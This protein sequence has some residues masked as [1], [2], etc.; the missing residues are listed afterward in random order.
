MVVL[1]VEDDDDIRNEIYKLMSHFFFK[2][3]VARNGEEGL[4]LFL[5]NQDEINLILSD[6]NMPEMNGIE[7]VKKIREFDK[8]INIFFITA[9]SD[10]E[11]LIEAINLRIQE[12]IVK[13]V[14]VRKLL[15]SINELALIIYQDE[16]L[17]NQKKELEK[18]KEIIDSNNILI[19]LD[20]N[21]KIYY[22]NEM[23]EKISGYTQNELLGK[24]FKSLKHN[25]TSNEIYT[26]IYEDIS[27]HLTWKGTLKQSKKDGED[28]I[29]DSFFTANYNEHGNFDGVICIQKDIT[30]EFNKERELRLTLMKEKSDIF[31]KS[32]EGSIEQ[33]ILI[34]ELKQQL[35]TSKIELAKALKNADTHMYNLE[36]LKLEMKGLNTELAF[37]RKSS[38]DNAAFKLSKENNDLRVENKKLKERIE[39]LDDTYQ[40]QIAQQKVNYEMRIEEIELRNI[41][42]RKQID[43]MQ[44]D[45]ILVQK[46]EYWK[47][48]AKTEL[49]RV[50][51]LEKQIIAHGDTTF[52]KKVFG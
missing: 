43:S 46:L 24:D 8:K 50:E 16:L 11:Y 38:K 7:M 32:K 31:K 40:S 36:K 1:Y 41:E 49:S 51:M 17:K 30:E 20:T 27:N 2:V 44:N 39:Y 23:F 4:E 52:M 15:F 34:N 12:Y 21:M 33:T 6:I 28:Y 45:E 22:V 9:Y 26:K 14:D 35:Q 13:P 19:K 10:S 47:E 48:K 29:C 42:L 37:F 3:Y 18:Y 25:D 5:N